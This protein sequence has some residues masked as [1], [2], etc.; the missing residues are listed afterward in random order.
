MFLSKIFYILSSSLV[1]HLVYKC[2][3]FTLCC[4]CYLE[5]SDQ[6]GQRQ[7]KS[8]VMCISYFDKLT[9]VLWNVQLISKNSYITIIFKAYVLILI[10]KMCHIKISGKHKYEMAIFK[11]FSFFF[12]FHIMGSQNLFYTVTPNQHQASNVK[13]LNV[14]LERD[15]R[16]G[17]PFYGILSK[18][19]K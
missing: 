9:E 3:L 14:R 19:K 16:N 8:K 7:A 6:R 2:Y 10:T 5:I 4:C 13:S 11:P 12:F 17:I 15:A 1:I 18:N